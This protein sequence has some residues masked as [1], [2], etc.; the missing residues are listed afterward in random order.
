MLAK[1]VPETFAQNNGGSG[2]D[3]GVKLKSNVAIVGYS[4]VRNEFYVGKWY[5]VYNRLGSELTLMIF[6]I[7]TTPV[8]DDI[9][10]VVP[11]FPS[12]IER[13]SCD[14][15]H[16]FEISYYHGVIKVRQFAQI[17]FQILN[18]FFSCK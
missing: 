9:S 10:A 2:S 4:Y 3:L 8:A 18:F 11:T 7:R 5:V 15:S 17:L 6:D 14:Q 16:A 1:A 13:L 12:P